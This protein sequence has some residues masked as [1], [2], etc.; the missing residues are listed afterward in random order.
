MTDAGARAVFV[1]RR[2]EGRGE[3]PACAGSFVL[4]RPL[5]EGGMGE[6]FLGENPATGQRA[7]VKVLTSDCEDAVARFELEARQLATLDHAAIPRLLGQG[8]TDTGRP[9]LAMEYV[10]GRARYR[11]RE[12][13]LVWDGRSSR[14]VCARL[15]CRPARPPPTRRPPRREAVERPRIRGAGGQAAGRAHRFRRVEVALVPRRRLGVGRGKHD[16]WSAA[17]ENAGIRGTRAG[18]AGGEHDGGRRVLARRAPVRAAHVRTAR[19]RWG[20]SVAGRESWTTGPP[21][22]GHRHARRESHR[23]GSWPPARLGGRAPDGRSA[24]P[25]RPRPRRA[26]GRRGRTGCAGFSRATGCDSSPVPSAPSG[27][28][29]GSQWLTSSGAPRCGLGGR[30]RAISRS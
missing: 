25:E 7:A 27:R 3:S 11:V 2:R 6:V 20:S 28:S 17:S 12:R 22:V 10:K 14:A 8:V 4:L 13:S 30:R 21:G 16:G 9:Y 24:R 18:A 29:R 5:G 23:P 1:V 26:R 19:G 15:Q